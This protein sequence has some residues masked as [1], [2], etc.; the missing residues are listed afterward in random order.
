MSDLKRFADPVWDRFFDFIQ[1]DEEPT[2][3]AEV[4][5]SLRKLGI[6]PARA[7]ARVKAALESTAA[8]AQLEEAREK[9]PSILAA[10]SQVAPPSVEGLRESLR[11]RITKTL[12]GPQQ[13]LAFRKLEGAATDEDLQALLTDIHRLQTLEGGQDAP[14]AGE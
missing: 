10:L 6:N 2:D 14:V 12:H 4:Q 1:A 5:E 11:E 13:A 3:R 8:K 7:I 9:R